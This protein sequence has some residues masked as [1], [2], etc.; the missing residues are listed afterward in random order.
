VRIVPASYRVPVF[1]MK[2][3]PALADAV[4]GDARVQRRLNRDARAERAVR[5]GTA[6]EAVRS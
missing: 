3:L 5:D 6:R 1:L 2:A 4:F